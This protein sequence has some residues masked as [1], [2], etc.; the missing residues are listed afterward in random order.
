M[1]VKAVAEHLN[2]EMGTRLPIKDTDGLSALR[3]LLKRLKFPI[4]PDAKGRPKKE[5]RKA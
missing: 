4:A 1:T 3:R 2:R 5:T